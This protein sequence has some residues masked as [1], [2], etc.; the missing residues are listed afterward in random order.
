MAYIEKIF[1]APGTGKTHNLVK[2]LQEHLDKNCP[3]DK[4]KLGGKD[5]KE[6]KRCFS[7][8]KEYFEEP[9][10]LETKEMKGP[11]IPY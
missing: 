1:G 8:K 9:E 11:E 6:D 4:N 5:R 7:I 2:R 10:D 3:F